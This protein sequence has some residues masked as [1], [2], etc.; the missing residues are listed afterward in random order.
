MQDT[1]PLTADVQRYVAPG[2]VPGGPGNALSGTFRPFDRLTDVDAQLNAGNELGGAAVRAIWD[3]GDGQLT[4]V[5]AWRYWNWRPQNDRDFTGL[6]LTTKS[7]NPSKQDQYTQ[8][9]RYAWTASG[10]TM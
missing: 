4:S 8:E 1:N 9:F 10:S 2:S 3:L 6:P 5:T 7:E